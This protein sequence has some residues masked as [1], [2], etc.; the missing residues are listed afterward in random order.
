MD[1]L[2]ILILFGSFIFIARVKATGGEWIVYEKPNE[3][4]KL[5]EFFG[6]IETI[7]VKVVAKRMESRGQYTYTRYFVTFEKLTN[8]E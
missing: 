7:D 5:G 3:I 1:I 2:I 4:D 8:K 6:Y